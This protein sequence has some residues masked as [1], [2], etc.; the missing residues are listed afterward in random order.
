MML[1]VPTLFSGNRTSPSDGQRE[2]VYEA[3]RFNIRLIT[4]Q[5]LFNG[6][7]A[8]NFKL[9]EQGPLDLV[10]SEEPLYKMFY[11]SSFIL[12][13]LFCSLPTAF[14]VPDS[15]RTGGQSI[16]LTRRPPTRRSVEDWGAWAKTQR[17]ALEAKYDVSSSR[18]R[19]SASSGTN[20]MTNQNSDTSY[21]GSLAI[22]TPPR[23]FYVVLDTE[24]YGQRAVGCDGSC[25]SS[26][27]TYN[28]SSSSS[29]RNLSEPFSAAY[30]SGEVAGYLYTDVVQMAGFS[31]N[32]QTFGAITH[33][34]DGLVISPVSGLLGLGW[35]SIANTKA[36][37]LWQTLASQGAWKDPV[38][39]FQL[40]RFL[41][42]SSA[43]TL[44]PGGSFTMGFVNSSL[45]T[46]SID[47]QNLVNTP[48]YWTL[49]L[50]QLTVNGNGV[51]LP[52]GSASLAAIDTGTTLVAG[53]SKS[54]QNFLLADSWFSSWYR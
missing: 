3:V 36:P 42:D 33:L 12:S 44:E 9:A 1:A 43:R 38:M 39:A 25:I 18:K 19:S 37:P 8:S 23:S 46:G 31:V 40:T 10:P 26:D 32:D 29:S 53:P 51:S 6:G 30:G 17:E 34:T 5:E 28:P 24:I 20:L 49:S 22:G 45:Y 52:S 21:F 50:T 2:L 4:D 47:Y 35:Q 27:A 16:T 15:S 54:I 7:A 11:S 48:G 13:V 41:N 14:A